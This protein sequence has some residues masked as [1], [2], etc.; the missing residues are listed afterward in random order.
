MR[1]HNT[2]VHGVKLIELEPHLDE[3]GIFAEGFVKAAWAKEGIDF[4][5]LQVNLSKSDRAGTIR[6]MHWQADP[7][8]QGKIVYAV[9]GAVFDAVV[10]VRKA[11]GTYGM[12]CGYELFPQANAL[13]VPKGVA[14]GFQALSDGATLLYL[15]DAP[16]SKACERGLRYDDMEAGIK[17]P[18][19]VVNV[20]PKDLKWPTFRE[21]EKP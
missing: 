13:F 8:S 16:Y 15:V 19:P 9:S 20:A 18:L 12:S 17:W 14:H 6:G 7:H 10:D 1:V 21:L 4:D 11:S 3:R 2:P 5:V